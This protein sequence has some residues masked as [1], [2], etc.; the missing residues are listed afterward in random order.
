METTFVILINFGSEERGVLIRYL[1]E[2]KAITDWEYCF[3]NSI[4]VKSPLSAKRISEIIDAKYKET[5]HLV[6]AVGEGYWG[7]LPEGFWE[8]FKK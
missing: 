2:R 5:R 3:G 1:E 7:R 4:V 6:I 8:I